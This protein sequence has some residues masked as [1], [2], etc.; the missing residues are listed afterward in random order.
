MALR[1]Q[2]MDFVDARLGMRDILEQNLTKYLLPKN[3][4]AW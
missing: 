3:V 1:K 4:N 2:I